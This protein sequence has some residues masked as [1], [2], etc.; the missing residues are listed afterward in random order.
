MLNA[1]MLVE[2]YGVAHK[3][4]PNDAYFTIF[5]ASQLEAYH[6]DKGLWA[7]GA[8]WSYAI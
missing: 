3:D 7:D 1:K 4:K 8:D 2:G 6:T 5:K